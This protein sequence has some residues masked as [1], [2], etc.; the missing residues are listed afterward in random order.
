MQS[1]LMVSFCEILDFLGI[2]MLS[3]ILMSQHKHL[4]ALAKAWLMAGASNFSVWENNEILAQ[5]PDEFCADSVKIVAP[6]NIAGKAIG[7]LHVAGLNGSASQARLQ[8]EAELIAQL[9]SQEDDLD[10]LTSELIDNQDQL[11]ALYN[12]TKST[13][14]HLEIDK[15]LS[16]LTEETWQLVKAEGAFILLKTQGEVDQNAQYPSDYLSD[17]ALHTV[18]EKVAPPR[19]RTI[20]QRY[21]GAGPTFS[22]NDLPIS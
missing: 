2:V 13:R 9:I 6:I 7:E 15:A 4:N 20:T 22:H 17:V 8:V 21:R 5:W 3:T 16:A 11:L 10:T 14:S 1:G 18:I 12:L 19:W